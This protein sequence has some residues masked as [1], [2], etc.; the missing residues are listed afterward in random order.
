[1][2]YESYRLTEMYDGGIVKIN[3]SK[4]VGFKELIKLKLSTKGRYGLK[5]IIDLAVHSEH[6][7]VSISSICERQGISERYM[8]QLISKLKKAGFVKSVR[9][10]GGGYQMAKP[11][12]SITVGDVLRVLEGDMKIVDCPQVEQEGDIDCMNADL[13]VTK[14]VWQKV[15]DSINNTLDNITLNELVEESKK[16]IK[17]SNEGDI[18]I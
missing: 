9:G 17:L 2:L 10:A 3:P 15:N 7:Y 16:A 13:C 5:A 1:M 11:L 12:N 4:L 18:I 8:E 14:Y 6:E